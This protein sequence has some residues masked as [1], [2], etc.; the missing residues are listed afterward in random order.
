MSLEN[1]SID[2]SLVISVCNPD[3]R[4]LKRCLNAVHNLDTSGITTEVILV[5]N[6]SGS[7]ISDLPYVKEFLRKAPSFKTMIVPA[8]GLRNARIAAIKETKGKYIV[9]FD[10]DTEPEFDYLQEL[11]KLNEQFPGIAAIGAGDLSVDFIDG[12][13]KKIENYARQAFRERHDKVIKFSGLPEWQE[14]YPFD[15]GL[16]ISSALLKE[17]A[18]LARDGRFIL[19][20][21]NGNQLMIGDDTQMVLLCVNKGWGAGVSPSL[22]ITQTIPGSR[23]SYKYLQQYVFGNGLC[24]ENCMSQV[25]SDY[26]EKLSHEIISSSRFFRLTINKYFKTLFKP[27]PDKTFDFIEFISLN[28][29]A[30]IAL[31]RPVPSAIKRLINFLK[32]A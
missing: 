31:N 28:A 17:Y 22:K 19:P 25:F 20:G 7:P 4:L 2:Y 8:L 10:Y 5:D 32:L 21:L 24:Y 30:Y 11:K 23:A 15:P 26:R 13:D 14:C 6:N 16:C 18:N 1:E 3:E 27:D 29:G 12:I 9:Y